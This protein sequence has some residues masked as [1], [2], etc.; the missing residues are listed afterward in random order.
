MNEVGPFDLLLVIFEANVGVE[1][2]SPAFVIKVLSWKIHPL[3]LYRSKDETLVPYADPAPNGTVQFFT[4][5]ADIKTIICSVRKNER[6]KLEKDDR[7]RTEKDRFDFSRHSQIA[8]E[9]VV[10]KAWKSKHAF[11]H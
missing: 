4:A 6:R 10:S 3:Y 11:E 2:D 9:I 7:P 5:I 1:L 8:A